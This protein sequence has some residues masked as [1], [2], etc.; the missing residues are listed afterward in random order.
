MSPLSSPTGLSC[1]PQRPLSFP[2]CQ[3]LHSLLCLPPN[4]LEDSS[5][6]V[7]CTVHLFCLWTTTSPRCPV[8]K[9]QPS[10]TQTLISGP[11]GSTE[12][13]SQQPI[14]HLSPLTSQCSSYS[15]ARHKRVNLTP[16][17]ISI[18]WN[19]G[20]KGRRWESGPPPISPTLHRR[21]LQA[22]PARSARGPSSSP[23]A[24]ARARRAG[25]HAHS[26]PFPCGV[27]TVCNLG[28]PFGP[29]DG[30][31]PRGCPTP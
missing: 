23:A 20:R 1:L 16:T 22:A 2:T 25:P 15:T 21:F 12:L 18:H 30:K 26:E 9:A 11:W 7:H 6:W 31:C 5:G 17:T 19:R 29:R 4:L 8:Q 14:L 24:R 27:G 28:E 13:P 10:P 3:N